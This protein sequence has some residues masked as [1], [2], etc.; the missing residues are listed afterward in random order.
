VRDTATTVVPSILAYGAVWGGLARQVGLS[1]G[2]LVAM[3][4]LVTA[5]TAQFVAL[6]MLR[7]GDPA[8]L[9]V[10]TAYIVNLRHYL[11]AAS[12]AP[13]FA[14]LSRW[15]L[16]VL[17]HGVTDE[18]YALTLARFARRP[19][20][21]AYFA[22]CAATTYLAWYA[23]AAAG[24]L[25][26]GRIP[27]PHRYGLDFVFPAVFVAILARTVRAPWQWAVAGAAAAVALGVK[28]VLGGTWHIALAGL[29]A[30]ALAVWLAPPGAGAPAG[31]AAVP[32]GPGTGPPA[33]ARPGDAA[34]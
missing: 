3:C 24:G 2:E 8:W 20:H 9:L 27:D 16:A 1:Q 15:R 29:G 6:P 10:V 26:G 18:A 22:G 4:L 28:A 23:G 11:M 19:P 25:L 17:A 34:R 21:A 30:S 14:H 13:Y 7:A 33:P 32:A 31:D 12:L 5:G